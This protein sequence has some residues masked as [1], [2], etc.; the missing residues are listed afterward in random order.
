MDSRRTMFDFVQDMEDLAGFLPGVANAL[1][2]LHDDLDN[3]LLIR[4]NWSGGM[5]CF[6]CISSAM[7]PALAEL[8]RIREG[9]DAIVA[10]A[11]EQKKG[12]RGEV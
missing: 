8:D 3:N 1:N 6:L 11:Y 9:L 2:I 4:Q 7:V 10:A 12:G 5:D